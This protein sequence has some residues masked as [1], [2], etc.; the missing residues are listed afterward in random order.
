MYVGIK[1]DLKANFRSWEQDCDNEEDVMLLTSIMIQRHPGI[2]PEVT[3]QLCYDW[4]GLD[5]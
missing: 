4:V 2:D 1:D 3:R 5:F